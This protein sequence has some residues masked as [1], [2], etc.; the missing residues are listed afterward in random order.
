MATADA[1]LKFVSVSMLSNTFLTE[2]LSKTYLITKIDERFLGSSL[3]QRLVCQFVAKSEPIA[4]A[5]QIKMMIDCFS[6]I[7][8]TTALKSQDY[9]FYPLF[10]KATNQQAQQKQVFVFIISFLKSSNNVRQASVV[11]V[12]CSSSSISQQ[13][14]HI[15]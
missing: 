7:V 4:A 6:S 1:D 14:N 5:Q 11:F 12:F 2:F 8:Y 15:T 13:C 10:W 9:L 3:H